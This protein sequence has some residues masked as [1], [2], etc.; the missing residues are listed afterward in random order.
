MRNLMDAKTC[1]R[2]GYAKFFHAFLDGGVYFPPSQYESCF[3]SSM[4]DGVD[5]EI[6]QRA[7]AQAL[8]GKA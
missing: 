6:T 8:R 5:L 7:V 2:E 3:I 1:S 4:H